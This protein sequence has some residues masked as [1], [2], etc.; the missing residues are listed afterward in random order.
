MCE[1]IKKNGKQCMISSKNS[2]CHIHKNY[3]NEIKHKEIKK[4]K[5][6]VEELT[7]DDK[8]IKYKKEIISLN[9]TLSNKADKH[10]E[11]IK[12]I[13]KRYDT[14]LEIKNKEIKDLLDLINDKENINKSLTEQ[15]KNMLKDYNYFQIVRS[16]EK[17]KETLNKKNIDV[18]TYKNKQFQDLR[19]RRNYIVHVE[20][21]K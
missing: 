1:F 21:L 15:V 20:S 2:Y 3:V 16:Y 17:Q 14:I 18:L 10:K 8:I 6:I 13:E 9:K 11:Q 19:F 12:N 7:K 4:E 5:E